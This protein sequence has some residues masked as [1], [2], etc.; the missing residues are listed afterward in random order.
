MNEANKEA[1]GAEYRRVTEELY[2][3]TCSDYGCEY[4]DAEPKCRTLIRRRR[5]LIKMLED[6]DARR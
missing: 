2:E 1:I 6:F 5:K 3:I 4:C